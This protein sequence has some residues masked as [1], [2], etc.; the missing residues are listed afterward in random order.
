ML[1]LIIRGGDVVDGTGAARRRADVGVKDGRIVAIGQ[2]DGEAARTIDATGKVVAPGFVDVHTHF[3][4]QIFWD[5]ALT[6]VAAA[7][8]HHRA[9][10]QLRLHHRP[11]LGRPVRRRLPDADARPGRG[12]APRVAARP[13]C[14]GRGAP[15]PSTS[16]RLEGRVGVNV[17]MMVGHSRHPPGRDGRR[18]QPSAPPP[19]TRSRPW[20]G[21][22]HDGLEAGGIGF[23]SSWAR[24]HNDADG[25][26]VPSRYATEQELVELCRVAGEHEGT[27][28]EFLADGRARSSRGPRSSWPTCRP[29][30]QRPLNWNILVIN[31]LSA[32]NIENQLV[33]RRR[34]PGQGR[35]GRRPHHPQAVRHPPLVRRRLRAR[36][37]ARLGARDDRSP[38]PRRRR[39]SPTRRPARS[40]T[41]RPSRPGPWSALADWTTKRIFDVVQPENRQYVGRT[42]GEIAT[43]QGRDP[44]DV[45]C[46]IVALRRPAHQLRARRPHLH[47]RRVEARASTCGATAGPSSAPPTP[48][49]TSTCSPPSTTR[50]CCWARPSATRGCC[51][52]RRPCT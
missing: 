34:R 2:V 8:R 30:A 24:T 23:S 18:R 22:S 32:P 3:D 47:R 28:L 39:S 11:A 12:H 13:A 15:P 41:S 46:D 16:T 25:Q 29:P 19:T 37:A 43:E 49:P 40:S 1:D 21:S 44:F 14:R 7:R 35:Q 6:P 10:R 26:M 42:I 9:R 20:A 36:R 50:R 27:S 31:A 5:G 52:S 33:G 38:R 48:A 45:L 51:R 17:G 4:A